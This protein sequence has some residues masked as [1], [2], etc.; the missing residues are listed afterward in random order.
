[1]N[2]MN[3]GM[4][5]PFMNNKTGP[6]PAKTIAVVSPFTSVSELKDRNQILAPLMTIFLPMCLSLQLALTLSKILMEK[7]NRINWMLRV[8]GGISFLEDW[9]GWMGYH[10]VLNF[11]SLLPLIWFVYSFV[12][13]NS[14]ADTTT[15]NNTDN[16]VPEGVFER[17]IK[18]A[19]NHGLFLWTGIGL[20]WSIE[21]ISFIRMLS[22]FV[23]AREGGNSFG[24]GKDP[25][26]ANSR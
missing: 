22:D 21:G 7:N 20:I 12:R 13:D 5:P 15:G 8:N 23:S 18:E 6:L 10:I 19:K 9:L 2:L 17:K 3:N 25:T 14:H 4:T 24:D 26:V 11:L 16:Y 1:M